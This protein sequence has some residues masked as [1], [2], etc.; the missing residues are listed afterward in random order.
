[1]RCVHCRQAPVVQ[2]QK[3]IRRICCNINRKFLFKNMI[4]MTM[5]HCQLLRI[6]C[7]NGFIL[8]FVNIF[9]CFWFCNLMNFSVL[10]R[11][12]ECQ[13]ILLLFRSDFILSPLAAEMLEL[14]IVG[15]GIAAKSE[16]RAI[17]FSFISANLNQKN[18]MQFIFSWKRSHYFVRF[19]FHPFNLNWSFNSIAL[20]FIRFTHFYYYL[21]VL[22]FVLSLHAISAFDV[23]DFIFILCT[24]R[25]FN[26]TAILCAIED[27]ECIFDGL[28]II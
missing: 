5:M 23:I 18:V 16:M 2:V 3:K 9:N 13:R 28:E 15:L 21:V 26:C 24:W 19:R 17:Q 20:A 7:V 8:Y 4:A 27:D 14:R 1:M 6:Y 22:F 12:I 10:F 11:N 25:I